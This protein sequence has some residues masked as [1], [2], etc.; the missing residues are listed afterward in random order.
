MQAYGAIFVVDG[1]NEDRLWEASK[2]LQNALTHPRLAR[3]PFLIVANKLNEGTALH[4]DE[5]MDALGPFNKNEQAF[6][7]CDCRLQVGLL[8]FKQKKYG[9]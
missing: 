3:K 6:I 2:E 7:Y 4:Y 8:L 1:A 5:L 9:I